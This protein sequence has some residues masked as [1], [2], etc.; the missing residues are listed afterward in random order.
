[1]SA[2]I[3]PNMGLHVWAEH[4]TGH[5]SVPITEYSVHTVQHETQQMTQKT[6]QKASQQA[7]Q[8]ATQQATQKATQ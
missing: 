5:K 1:M 7:T 6:T 8:K 2:A 4:M 3:S